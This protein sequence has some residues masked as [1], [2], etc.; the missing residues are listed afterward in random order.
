MTS[1]GRSVRKACLL[2]GMTRA[3]CNYRPVVADRDEK[4]RQRMRELTHPV[5]KA[6]VVGIWG[7]LD[8]V[9][10][11]RRWIG[12]YGPSEPRGWEGRG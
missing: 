2:L 9:T 6:G 10:H 8:P 1:L 11:R 3:S 4:L 5:P 7:W 12:I